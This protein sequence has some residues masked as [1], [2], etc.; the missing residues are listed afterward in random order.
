MCRGHCCLGL[1]CLSVA[2]NGRQGR[3]GLLQSGGELEFAGFSATAAKCRL[4]FSM[5]AFKGGGKKHAGVPEDSGL[6]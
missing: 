1:S 5:P 2:C 4:S 6:T 3:V